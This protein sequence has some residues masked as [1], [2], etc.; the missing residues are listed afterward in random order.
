MSIVTPN[1]ELTILCTVLL[2]A[3]CSTAPPPLAVPEQPQVTAP[4][5]RAPTSMG[6]ANSVDLQAVKAATIKQRLM[7]AVYACKAGDAYNDFVF[8]YREDLKASDIALQNF[9]NRLHGQS[10]DRAFDSFKTRM[11][12]TSA[13]DS[14]ADSSGYCR[15]TKAA[16]GTAMAIPV[17]SLETFLAS[18]TM[19]STEGFS[20]CDVVTASN[21]NDG[22]PINLNLPR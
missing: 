7:V 10:G 19:E 14:I 21:A 9:F 20:R 5:A 3:A 22:L 15:S 18:Q 16:F 12:N 17:K 13:I 2:L 8:A 11:A 6:C 1:V 4:M